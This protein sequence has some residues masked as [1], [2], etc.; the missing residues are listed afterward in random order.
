MANTSILAAFERM[1]Q[2]VVAALGSKATAPIVSKTDITAGSTPLAD[3]QMYI[4]Y[5]E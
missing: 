3:G 5:E 4:V 1:W 2:H